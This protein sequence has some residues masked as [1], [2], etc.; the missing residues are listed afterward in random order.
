MAPKVESA[1]VHFYAISRK[2][3][4]LADSRSAT[5]ADHT[6]IHRGCSG[7][8]GA[9]KLMNKR[10]FLVEVGVGGVIS[11]VVM[12]KMKNRMDLE[13]V[14]VAKAARVTRTRTTTLLKTKK[15]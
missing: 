14:M 9:Q 6:R 11:R 13:Q 12:K 8:I 4:N 5:P 7:R 3:H 15:R 10:D 1:V 2:R